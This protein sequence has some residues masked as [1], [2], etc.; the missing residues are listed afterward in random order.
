MED[1]MAEDILKTKEFRCGRVALIG[2]PNAGKST[3]LNTILGKKLAIVSHRPQTTRNQISGILSCPDF[4]VVFL[5]T[6]GVHRKRGTLNK[7]LVR[8]A[9][10]SVA[11]A[12]VVAL[13]VDSRHC[14][15]KNGTFESEVQPLLREIMG[16]GLPACVVLNKVDLVGVK[17][18]LLPLLQQIG[19]MLLGVE[20][21]LVSALQSEG[22]DP[23][24][25]WLVVR[26]PKQPALFPYDQISTAPLRFL[27]AE[28][29]REKLF[30][31]LREELPYSIAVDVELWEEDVLR[32][33]TRI[34]VVIY[35]AR[36][37]HKAIVIGTRGQGLKAAGSAARP[38]IEALLGQRVYLGLWVKVRTGW[39]EDE[40]FMQTL[41]LGEQEG[42]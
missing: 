25:D 37:G 23:L 41:V 22:L 7:L 10:Q 3:L 33:F 21:F 15:V 6:P 19:A 26:L 39:N 42:T 14:L 4:Q 28:I 40:R 12:N 1:G 18:S 38:E 34:N 9:W 16:T 29:I 32:G 30:L 35:V 27:V 13:I 20:C 36:E 5:D 31:Q 11:S 17:S 24:L 8:M 2:P